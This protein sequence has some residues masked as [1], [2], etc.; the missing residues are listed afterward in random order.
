M[1]LNSKILEK[2]KL[3][4]A[5]ESCRR[6]LKKGLKTY[7]AFIDGN[8]FKSINDTYGHLVGDKVIKEMANILALSLREDDQILRF[9]GDE[10]VILLNNFDEEGV[11]PFVQRLQKAVNE[12]ELI[13]KIAKPISISVGVAEYDEA[14]HKSV[15][16]LVADADKLMYKAKSKAPLY[17]AFS[18]SDVNETKEDSESEDKKETAVNK[19]QRLLFNLVAKIIIEENPSFNQ[20]LL[21]NS[22]RYIWKINGM[23]V[24]TSEPMNNLIFNIKTRYNYEFKRYVLKLL[25][26]NFEEYKDKDLNELIEIINQHFKSEKSTKEDQ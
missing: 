5:F 25:K 13:A 3:G 19:R 24:V 20:K 14:K 18:S 1:I 7:L 12:S 11:K 23:R 6:T 15:N 16:D 8:G 21:L 22:M 17:L 9:G 2:E 4:E 10:F 26:D